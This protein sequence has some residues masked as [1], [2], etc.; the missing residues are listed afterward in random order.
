MQSQL[1]VSCEHQSRQ[2]IGKPIVC[3][4]YVKN[5]SSDVLSIFVSMGYDQGKEE[6]PTFLQAGESCTQ[7]ELLPY[8]DAY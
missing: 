6:A 7:V 3:K 1:Q 8:N 4:F 5:I 2:K